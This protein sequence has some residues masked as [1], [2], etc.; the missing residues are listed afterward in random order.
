MENNIFNNIIWRQKINI[1]KLLQIKA[2]N[3]FKNKRKNI[4]FVE[5]LYKNLK[6][7]IIKIQIWLSVARFCSRSLEKWYADI[8]KMM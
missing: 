2:E 3:S 5:T 4:D 8:Y 6:D 7:Y 1:K